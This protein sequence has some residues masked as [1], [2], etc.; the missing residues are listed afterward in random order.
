MSQTAFVFPGQGSQYVGMGQ[1][2]YEAHASVRT[3]YE[4]ANGILGF[5]LA[6]ISFSGPE[7]TLKQTQYTQ[8]ALYVHSLAVSDLLLENGIEAEAA[9]GHSLGEF[10][11]LAC[12]GVFS[13]E[14]GL[15]IV[16]KRAELMQEAADRNPGAMAAII[17][18]EADEVTA[19]CEEAAPAGVVQPANFNSPGQ[20]V[21]SGSRTGVD[22]AVRLAKGRGAKR[23]LLL[24][25]SGGF[26][27][28]LMEPAAEAIRNVLENIPFAAPRVPVWTN[29]SARAV[30][31]PE[32]IRES[33]IQQL[34]HSVRWIE[35]VEDMIA[36]GVS[37]FIETGPNK[38]LSGLIK[39]IRRDADIDACGTAEDVAR[40]SGLQ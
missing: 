11:A 25:V 21:I 17:G 31:D 35:T 7:E 3:L 10:S 20:I 30:R 2:L 37:R 28:P 12:A 19:L 39:R 5:D 4:K 13:F 18:L 24:P 33:L 22:E 34:T 9:A 40:F 23:A 1:D 27:S 8:P 32:V 15:R 38:V 6:G 14:N 29:V 26:H 36:S 16:R